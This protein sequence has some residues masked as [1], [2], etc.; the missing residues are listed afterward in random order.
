[1]LT[2]G[3]GTPNSPY[4]W[5]TTTNLAPPVIWTTNSA[6]TLDGTGAFSNAIPINR[7]EPGRYFRMRLP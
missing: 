1:V 6:G 7:I 5:L 3:G 4:T 2:G